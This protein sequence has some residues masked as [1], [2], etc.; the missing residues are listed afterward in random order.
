MRMVTVLWWSRHTIGLY[1]GNHPNIIFS[2]TFND[3]NISPFQ[4]SQL[5]YLIDMEILATPLTMVRGGGR[6]GL[7]CRLSSK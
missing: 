3:D 4:L 6:V 7:G 5:T 1:I 2:I